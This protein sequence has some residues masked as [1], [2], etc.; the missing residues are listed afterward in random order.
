MWPATTSQ[1]AMAIQSCTKVAPV[2]HA[3]GNGSNQR[4]IEPVASITGIVPAMNAAL[5]F[6]PALN[7]PTRSSAVAAPGSAANDGRPAVQRDSR[8]MSARTAS[9]QRPS[10]GQ[11]QRH[12]QGE[13]GDHVHVLH[14]LAAADEAAERTDVQ[15]E[16]GDRAGRARPRGGPVERTAR[17]A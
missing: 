1:M 10:V 8:R 16:P 3:S 2:R 5:T 9:R 17:R 15:D 13:A 12:R 7:L 4:M 6:C 11:D 14:Q